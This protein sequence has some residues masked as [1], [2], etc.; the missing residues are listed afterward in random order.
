[1]GAQ[2]PPAHWNG[3][4]ENLFQDLYLI[5]R[6]NNGVTAQ[7]ANATVNVLFNSSC[8]MCRFAAIRRADPG[9]QRASV[10][11]TPRVKDS[12]VYAQSLLCR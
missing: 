2:L 9:H 11:L 10:E 7:Q 6:L 3:R 8:K 1:M 5:G 12:A 4:T